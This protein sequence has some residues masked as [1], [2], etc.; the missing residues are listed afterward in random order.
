MAD[1]CDAILLFLQGPGVLVNG[2]D[3]ETITCTDISECYHCQ[4]FI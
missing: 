2:G 3:L 4:G 1:E